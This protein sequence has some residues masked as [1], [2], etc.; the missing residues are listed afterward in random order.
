MTFKQY[1]KSVFH[2]LFLIPTLSLLLTLSACSQSPIRPT[3]GK[4]ETADALNLLISKEYMI[5]K[6]GSYDL[7]LH[8]IRNLQGE[9]RFC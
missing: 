8:L 6:D 5:N 4:G 9:K 7:H 1:V 3:D 2:P